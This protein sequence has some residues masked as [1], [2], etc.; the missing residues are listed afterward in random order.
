MVAVWVFLGLCGAGAEP[1]GLAYVFP[2][3]GRR[4]ER[5]DVRFGGY[6]LHGQAGFEVDG[7]GFSGGGALRRVE[8]VF[9]DGPL[10]LRPT[11]QQREDY[12]KD[13]VGTVA[14]GKDADVSAGLRVLTAQGVTASL[15]FLSGDFPEVVEEEREGIE[16]P[17]RVSVPVTVNG[18]MFPREDRDGWVFSAKKGA[19]MSCEVVAR[20]LGYGWQPV[21]EL[22][23]PRG[24]AVAGAKWVQN[25]D[26]DPS[27]TFEAVEDGDYAVEL[28]DA[29]YGGSQAH[30]Y[31]MTVRERGAVTGVFPLGG[32]VGSSVKVHVER[33]IGGSEE[34]IQSPVVEGIQG[35]NGMFGLAGSWR[36]AG[37]SAREVTRFGDG[38]VEGLED[39][40]LPVPASVNGFI[41][42][43]GDRHE[44]RVRMGAGETLRLR[45]RA[46]SLGS[47]MDPVVSVASEE[48]KE[49]AKNDD[50]GDGTTDAALT[51]VAA[52]EGVYLVR[53]ND[54]FPQRH[55]LSHA[56]R[57]EVGR[58]GAV[59]FGLR[60]AT[61]FYNAVRSAPEG[62]PEPQGGKPPAK[63]LGLKV[64]L[65]EAVG[66][67][68]EVVLEI[69][70]L[71]AGVTYE[72][73]LIPAKAKGVEVR[74]SVPPNTPLQSVPIRVRG[75][76]GEG[77][78][79]VVR[80]ADILGAVTGK[81]G[82][83]LFAVVPR[84]PFRFIGEY[85]VVN[86]QPAGTTLKKTYRIDRGGYDGP[87]TVNLSDKQVRCL[88]RLQAKPVEVPRGAEFFDFEVLYPTEVQLGWTSRVQLMVTG[89]EAEPDGS[90]HFLT[91]TSSDTDDQ[92]I[93]IVT[94]GL[95]GVSGPRNSVL[96]CPGVVEIPVRVRR[97]PSIEGRPVRVTL[98]HPAYVKG[99]KSIPLEIPAGDGDGVLRVEISPGA[100]PFLLPLE[101]FAETD[102]PHHASM[103]VDFVPKS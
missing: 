98:R 14:I 24:L 102:G 40:L 69:E 89:E 52:K 93:S 12:P 21:L 70:G 8:T 51:Y 5:V 13:H 74:F 7:R 1:P 94:A 59:S 48:G 34:F 90:R 32:C 101:V 45:V 85:M 35:L 83:V 99:L 60:I 54:R 15:R 38:R 62:A 97:H 9:F 37:S 22:K 65:T 28:R 81:A 103:S 92:M 30:I 3:G 20:G 19:V 75:R 49:L 2:A 64:D 63:P 86:D 47:K 4:G 10:I 78:A 95:L 68:K 18:R 72:P 77:D 66:V 91:Y 88:Q 100:G 55:G 46:G 33:A 36:F 79:A 23:G 71:P 31:R 67:A 96:A 50:A 26:G 25:R 16:P 84:V 87:L 11:S 44:W 39:G 53:V 17:V 42:A 29:G 82:T 41:G 58:G 76:V 43:A 56:Y 73:R 6:Y 61:D 27:V 80:D 57:M